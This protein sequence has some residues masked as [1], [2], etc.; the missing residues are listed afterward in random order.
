MAASHWLRILL[1]G[2]ITG[3][4]WTLLSV[5]VLAVVGQ[6]FVAA[7]PGGRLN[8]PGG[9]HGLL[10]G[11]NLAQ[12]VWG[13][14]IYTVLRARFR[15]GWKTAAVAGFAWWVIVSLQSSKWAALVAVPFKAALALLVTTLPAIIVAM[16]VGAWCYERTNGRKLEG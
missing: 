14:W 11:L 13:I 6:E 15:P 5:I 10:F 8:A 16:A 2:L 1:C 3:F 7:V 4:V 12:A 9:Q